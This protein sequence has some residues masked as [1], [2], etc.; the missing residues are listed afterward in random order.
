MTPQ[1][2][3]MEEQGKGLSKTNKTEFF[4]FSIFL[5][6]LQGKEKLDVLQHLLSQAL[7]REDHFYYSNKVPCGSLGSGGFVP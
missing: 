7:S 2:E 5:E 6:H 1:S 3:A 4:L